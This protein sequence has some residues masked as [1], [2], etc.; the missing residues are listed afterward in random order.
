MHFFS[1][2]N[3]YYTGVT[4]ID[5][6]SEQAGELKLCCFVLDISLAEEKILKSIASVLLHDWLT[7]P[8]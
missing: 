6:Y 2:I 7:L 3:V 1:T 4:C 8:G 5:L